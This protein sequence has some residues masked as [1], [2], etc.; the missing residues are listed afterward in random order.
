MLF[1]FYHHLVP[2]PPPANV[3]Y[4]DVEETRVHLSWDPPELHQMFSI[5]RYYITYRKYG[6]KEWNNDTISANLNQIT[7]FK[8]IDLES[9]TFYILRVFAKNAYGPGKESDKIEIKTKKVKGIFQY[10]F[11]LLKKS[12]VLFFK[13]KMLDRDILSNHRVQLI[14][15]QS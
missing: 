8:V 12:G 15:I 6:E 14:L 5:E 3:T 1:L 10:S 4:S 13:H 7:N 9:D 11:M 2:P